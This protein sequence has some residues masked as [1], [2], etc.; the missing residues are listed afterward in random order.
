M[1]YSAV[2]RF[3]S[4]KTAHCCINLTLTSQIHKVISLIMKP[5]LSTPP[6]MFTRIKQVFMAKSHIFLTL[7]I[8]V[9]CLGLSDLAT[10]KFIQ[11]QNNKSW[12]A[13]DI[14]GKEIKA[15]L[16]LKLSEL[17]KI[18]ILETYIATLNG[19]ANH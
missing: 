11:Q 5:K 7:L 2:I 6:R 16:D 1:L 14:K 13:A 15:L 8:F 4:D 3:K 18:N 17:Y 19:A 10:T 9:A 12:Q